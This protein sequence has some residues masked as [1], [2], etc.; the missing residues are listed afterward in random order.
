MDRE[1]SG[2]VTGAEVVVSL[3]QKLN[4]ATETS[5]RLVANYN[6]AMLKSYGSTDPRAQNS[7]SRPSADKSC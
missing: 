6:A 4:A 7:D 1:Q 2:K 5:R 3:A